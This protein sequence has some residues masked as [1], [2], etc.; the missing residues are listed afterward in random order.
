MKNKR[1]ERKIA[2]AKRYAKTC[3]YTMYIPHVYDYSKKDFSWWD[4]ISFR[5]GS[6]RISVAWIH[7][8]MAYRDKVEDVTY[9]MANAE[10]PYREKGDWLDETTPN[11]KK[12]GKSRKKV[13]SHTMAHSTKRN[14]FFDRWGELMAEHSK[15]SDIVIRPSIHIEQWQHARGVMITAP[16]E[17]FCEE[18]CYILRN[19]VASLLD[20]RNTLQSLFGDYTYSKDDWNAEG[21]TM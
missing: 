14:G 17:V 16:L 13:I 20:G 3:G 10:F 19:V 21:H 18:D 6:Q 2:S 4:D 1:V 15:T 5:F 9:E 11:Y 12:V 7:P 8:R